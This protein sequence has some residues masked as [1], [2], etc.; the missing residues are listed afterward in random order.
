MNKKFFSIIA[1]ISLPAAI[2]AQGEISAS[3][4]LTI[5]VEMQGSFSNSK[6]PLWLNANKYGL[7]SLN[8]DNGY[9]RGIGAY[10][11]NY[12]DGKYEIK[13]G[14]DVAVPIGYK[15]V[16]YQETYTSHF[17]LQQAY[18]EG[19]YKLGYLSIGAKERPMELKNNEL[20]SGSQ[21]LGINA[22][23]VP[24]VRLGL[25]DYWNIPLT[26]KWLS[27]KGH[28]AYGIMTDGAWEESF[29]K[30]SRNKYNKNT[31]YHEKAG[32]LRIGKEEKFPLIL[33]LGLE[34]AAQFG[35]DVY[36]WAGT[37]QEGY[38]NAGNVTF[39]SGLKSYWHAFSGTGTDNGE[40]TYSNSE[41]NI[42]G[43]WVARLNW[44]D[45]NMTIGAYFDHY[46]EDH[47]GMFML[48]Y[49]GYGTGDEWGI[50]KEKKY[51][52][53]SLKDGL[54]GLDVKLK[55]FPYINQLVVEYMNTRYQSGPIY[56]DHT[57]NI[58]NHLG[59]RDGYYSH[60]SLPGWQHWGQVM[61]NPLFMSPMYNTDGY[62][63]IENDRFN[64]WHLGVAG[65]PFCGFHYRTKL[66]WQR[67][68][69]TYANP[70]YTPKENISILVEASYKFPE[71]TKLHRLSVKM[72]Y[73]ADFGKLLGNNSG[74]QATLRY[75]IR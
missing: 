7:S 9:L 68:L 60:S 15:S 69:G 44:N 6:T 22:R 11:K 5:D 26:N 38:A 71:T 55:K 54:V 39:S 12:K 3:N 48:D 18:V 66:S 56:H 23:P 58:S 21:T 45:D 20:S 36:N 4:P 53:Y 10:D 27:F 52:A 13:A 14:L 65:N 1:M 74:F 29:A 43:S 72:A 37:D 35:G 75:N 24:Q 67:G 8:A 32:Y 16:G 41:G 49:D 50:R 46:F 61:G 33:T 28:L 42:L 70:Y 57:E 64:A 63:A 34:M 30:G 62:I 51:F 17:I 59:G 47:S 19:R 40:S 25:A 2:F 31:R 73:G